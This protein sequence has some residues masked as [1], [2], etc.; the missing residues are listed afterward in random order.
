M[1]EKKSQSTKKKKEVIHEAKIEEIKPERNS[2]IGFGIIFGL[3]VLLVGAGIIWCVKDHTSIIK[4]DAQ[5]FKEEYE[6]YNGKTNEKDDKKYSEI[7]IPEKNAMTYATYSE[8]LDMLEEKNEKSAVIYFGFPTCPWCRTL[9][10]VLLEAQ[11][12]VGIE[13]IYYLN[14][15]DSRDTKVLKDGKVKTEKEGTKEY[16]K[17]LE[18]LDSVLGEYEGLN[19]SSIKRLYFPTVVFVKD[20]KVVD[21]HIGTLD[22]QE[23]GHDALSEDQKKEFKE[24]LINKMNKTIACDSAC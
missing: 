20:G 15:L 16:K 9:L 12:E 4:T 14:A 24:M 17:L 23:D 22:S 11:E 2:K 6:Q 19:D 7:N 18:K 21:S 5:K 10:P 1:P 3:F 13:K 8:V